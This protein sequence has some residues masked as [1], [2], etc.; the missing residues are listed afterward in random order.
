MYGSVFGLENLIPAV[1]RRPAENINDTLIFAVMVGAVVIVISMAFHLINAVRQ[2]NLGELLFSP[3]GVA[4]ILFYG[5]TLRL[6]WNVFFGGGELTGGSIFVVCI[7]LI[8]IAF[9]VPVMKVIN[10]SG[11]LITGGV[12]MFLFSTVLEMVEVLLSYATNTISFVRVGAFAISHAGMMGVVLMLSRNAA[13]THNPVVIA[14]GNLLVICIEGLLVGIQALRLDFY[15]IFS[16]FYSG[17]GRKFV[18][19]KVSK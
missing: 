8:F 19:Y 5:L 2:K 18:A 1:W 17:N 4:G 10:R 9:K 11:K 14:F 13:G 3:N 15:E 7:P 12:G 6:I 16:R